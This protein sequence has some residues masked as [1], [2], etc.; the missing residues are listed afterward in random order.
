LLRTTTHTPHTPALTASTCIVR[1][2]ALETVCN[3]NEAG[4]E[5]HVCLL[6]GEWEAH[7][8]KD[9]ST[10]CVGV[11]GAKIS[12]AGVRAWLPLHT[13]KLATA[14]GT[15]RMRMARCSVSLQRYRLARPCLRTS[16]V[17]PEMPVVI[18]LVINPLAFYRTQVSIT[19]FGPPPGNL[20]EPNKSSPRVPHYLG[21]ISILPPH[22]RPVLPR[23]LFAVFCK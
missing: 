16:S 15:H 23:G 6:H 1:Q 18:Q 11:S 4:C 9:T 14:S 20:P 2:C 3:R 5:V 7:V 10:C 17:L 21:S 8:P 13:G 22:L 12:L 19:E